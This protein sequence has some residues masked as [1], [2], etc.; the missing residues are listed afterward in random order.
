[1]GQRALPPRRAELPSGEDPRQVTLN[2]SVPSPPSK[3]RSRKM[4]LT[5]QLSE[6]RIGSCLSEPGRAK[7]IAVAWEDEMVRFMRPLWRRLAS[8]NYRFIVRAV[9]VAN[10]DRKNCTL[11]TTFASS[12]VL[13]NIAAILFAQTERG[14]DPAGWYGDDP[15][16]A[17]TL[18]GIARAH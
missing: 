16:L 14:A 4:Q 11:G 12:S 6:N 2:R 8:R 1:M 9:I 15:G 5:A 7:H 17:G 3:G 18:R 13:E 10:D